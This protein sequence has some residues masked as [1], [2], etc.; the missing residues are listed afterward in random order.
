MLPIWFGFFGSASGRTIG[1]CLRLRPP[2][3]AP[4]RQ[5]GEADP[6]PG[7]LASQ[8]R[9]RVGV[10]VED[11]GGEDRADALAR[12][13][14][15][16][17]RSRARCCRGGCPTSS[18]CS[19]PRGDR[20]GS[21]CQD[22]AAQLRRADRGELLDQPLHG[23]R[24]VHGPQGPQGALAVRA[25]EG[26][27]AG[28]DRRSERHQRP[29]RQVR[30]DAVR[31]GL[32]LHRPRRRHRRALGPRRQREKCFAAVAGRRA[33]PRLMTAWPRTRGDS[34]ARRRD[35]GP[36]FEPVQ[37][38]LAIR[39]RPQRELADRRRPRPV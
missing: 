26:F 14:T 12:S 27:Q 6:V 30:D 10:A 9:R 8:E 31:V 28:V 35:E 17:G 5:P 24:V 1:L 7:Q 15:R 22:A 11:R 3:P 18:P 36:G 33:A 32:V 2:R 16:R 25:V 19:R 38:P 13:P 37:F 20:A 39:Q 34:S 23:L 21:A 4:A 29:D